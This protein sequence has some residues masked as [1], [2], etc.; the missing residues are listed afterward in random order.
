MKKM[1]LKIS[2]LLAVFTLIPFAAHAEMV[3]VGGGGAAMST[4]FDSIG[5]QLE[6]A[7]GITLT[8][9]PSTPANGLVELANGSLD[10]ATAA[11]SVEAMVAGA[12]KNNVTVDPAKLQKEQIG[13]NRTVLF[14]NPANKVNKLTKNQIKGIF[15][16][17][18][19][20]WKE[21]GGD[22][23][24]ILVVWGVGTPGQNAQFAKE[25]LDGEAV[26]KEIVDATNYASIKDVVASTPEAIGI[27]PFG[28]ADQ[29][30]RVIPNDP[31]LTSPII[32]V[33]I[34]KPTAA[35]QKIID[36]VK[37]E[38]RQYTKQ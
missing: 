32:A 20:N 36:Y 17:K 1:S 26:T 2:V 29:F 15:T 3:R 34:G 38:G 14:V 37:G 9:R 12:A 8:R 30:V 11:V 27:D 28:M 16:G 5:T 21:V 10:L 13:T 23:N 33:T 25:V 31:E 24:P 6:K 35:V 7:T 22:D 4:I 19:V 18:I